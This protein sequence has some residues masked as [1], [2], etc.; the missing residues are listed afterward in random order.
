MTVKERVRAS[1]VVEKARQNTAYADRIGLSYSLATKTQLESC[2]MQAFLTPHT[3]KTDKT[4]KSQKREKEREKM[5]KL[6]KIALA[7]V[8]AAAAFYLLVLVTAWL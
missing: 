8:G 5:K 6:G 7:I 2:V 4:A 3:E 1:R